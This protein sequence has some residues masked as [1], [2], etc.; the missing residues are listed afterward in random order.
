VR[1]RGLATACALALLA[2]SV[3]ANEPAI[4]AAQQDRRGEEQTF[5]T[6][7]EWFLVF[8]PAEYAQYVR[9]HTPDGFP[10]WGHIGQLWRA[11]AGV[12]HE[13]TS[14]HEPTNWG[15]HVMIVVIS[16]STTVEYAARSAYETC[17][18]RISAALSG[19]DTQEDAYAA[20]VAQQYVDF[21]RLRPWYEFDFWA[22][23]RGLWTQTNLLGPHLLRKLERKYALTT[24]YT[25]KALY[26]WVI[27]KA[28][29]TAYDTPLESTSVVARDGSRCEAQQV[30]STLLRQISDDR[31]LLALP[32]Y[33]P[34][35]DSALALAQCGAEFEEIAGNRTV[36]LTSVLGPL[37]RTPPLGLAVMTR[38]P[39]ITQPGLERLVLIVPVDNLGGLL[40]ALG[41]AGLTLEHVFDY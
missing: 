41:P 5:L 1:A 39:I 32:R 10:F 40:R 28:T 18:G 38:Q 37:G 19:G 17:I 35:T 21:I 13:T 9:G 24:E 27:T 29:H 14:R 23:L 2:L 8:S 7:P 26:G 15:Y 31:A 11:Y 34:F 20:K 30:H 3:S 4:Y 22:R 12:I 6:F 33:A 16:L 36:I 25:V